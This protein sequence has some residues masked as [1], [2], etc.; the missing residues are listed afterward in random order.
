MFLSQDRKDA[1]LRE[2]WESK[3]YKY[4]PK[5]KY[6]PHALKE[7][8]GVIEGQ[9]VL[10]KPTNGEM[11]GT[12]VIV[13]VAAL[14]A[15]PYYYNHQIKS[16]IADT[17]A[18]NQQLIEIK[19]KSGNTVNL[20]A[21]D[22]KERKLTVAGAAADRTDLMVAFSNK[23]SGYICAMPIS[24]SL[25]M[26]GLER[27]G[28]P[29]SSKEQ[30]REYAEFLGKEC[31]LPAAKVEAIKKNLINMVKVSAAPAGPYS[32]VA[33]NGAVMEQRVVEPNLVQAKG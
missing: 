27:A 9:A 21:L 25:V 29:L 14:I 10:R 2:F 22:S 8:A 1:A 24:K 26:D 12:G 23:K 15:Q 30:I 4:D 5:N 33:T 19:D 13:A 28:S 16:L 20:N 32:S 17:L 3:G 6:Y 31:D 11:V 18:N 7:A